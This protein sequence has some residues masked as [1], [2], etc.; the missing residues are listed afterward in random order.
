MEPQAS[1]IS[2]MEKR[3]RRQQEII[4]G[5]RG[6]QAKLK[7]RCK[8][9][10]KALQ[11]GRERFRGAFE[12]AGIGMI[13]ANT[14]AV[15]LDVNSA[16]CKL[17]GFTREELLGK[18]YRD[19]THPGDIHKDHKWMKRLLEGPEN[20]CRMEKRYITK[21]GKV[22]WVLVHLALVRGADGEPSCF[23]AQVQDIT[24][25]KKAAAR[26]KE[27][28]KRLQSLAFELSVSEARQQKRLAGE[29]HDNIGQI[30]ALARIQLTNLQ[31]YV[32]PEGR[33][34][35]DRTIQLLEQCLS[36]ARTLIC[37]LAPPVLYDAGLEAAVQR[38]GKRLEAAYG[39]RFS[40]SSD[41]RPKP[42]HMEKRVL[43]FQVVR[44]LLVNVVKHAGADQVRVTIRR[45]G[46]NIIIC[47]QDNGCGDVD[48]NPETTGF[49]LFSIRERL[50][51]A[52]GLLRY[53]S[54]PDTGTHVHLSAPLDL[55]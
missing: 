12:Y 25:Q 10:E 3:L 5:L 16:Q 47:V 20:T 53:T 33:G 30:V 48:F 19:V 44:E 6:E 34:H 8:A 55:R 37:Q 41:G 22:I 38:L 39:L 15:I 26:L 18:S 28:Q 27:Y 52:G 32:L 9:C 24:A 49:G 35:L 50:E 14:D 13:L 45:D 46:D 54:R 21:A 51:H 17:L 36:Y 43:L 40:Y 23:V 42:L 4:D 31:P 7:A 11:A 29:L 1:R 2:K